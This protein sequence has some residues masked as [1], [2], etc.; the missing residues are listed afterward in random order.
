MDYTTVGTVLALGVGICQYF[1]VAGQTIPKETMKLSKTQAEL[2]VAMQNGE[3]VYKGFSWSRENG[4]LCQKAAESMIKKGMAEI[5]RIPTY[6]PRLIPTES[7]KN[8]RPSK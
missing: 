1:Q 6:P 5:L 4:L 8:W 2:L 3:R 7:G